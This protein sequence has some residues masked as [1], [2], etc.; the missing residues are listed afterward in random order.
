MDRMA[1]V[2]GAYIQCAAG[3]HI[4]QLT[5]T[6]NDT[7]IENYNVA[8][9]HDSKK[10][11]NIK[12]FGICAFTQKPCDPQTHGQWLFGEPSILLGNAEV[13]LDTESI[14]FC[15]VGGV[16]AVVEQGQI[17]VSLESPEL[18]YKDPDAPHGL[19]TW[20]PVVGSAGMAGYAAG[21]GNKGEQGMYLLLAG[22]DAGT[23]GIGGIVR[24]GAQE[25]GKAALKKLSILGAGRIAAGNANKARLLA[26]KT[27]RQIFAEARA[28]A[29]E[30]TRIFKEKGREAFEKAKNKLDTVNAVRGGEKVATE[31]ARARQLRLN[32]IAGDLREAEVKR[33]LER[34]GHQVF[35]QVTVK[36]SQTRR[37]V[38]HLIIDGKTGKMRAIEVKS[39]N[40]KRNKSQISKD[41]AM[42][43]EG[44]TIIGKNAPDTLRGQRM[45][46]PTEVRR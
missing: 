13:V 29:Q 9:V 27:T 44:G 24:K 4:P 33:E 7:E 22:L 45:R 11:E 34:E 25:S 12:P 3:T 1:V 37:V 40:A 41:N 39:G 28:R 16:I 8:S 35:S 42:K 17:S 5:V 32:K 31:G 18:A 23:L 20:V 2:D 26:G 38:D 10:G 15:D 21:K 46:I 14:L 19:W 43:T 30:L 6:P 36:T